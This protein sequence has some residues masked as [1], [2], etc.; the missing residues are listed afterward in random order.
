MKIKFSHFQASMNAMFLRHST[1]EETETIFYSLR[2]QSL[3]TFR[4]Q[5][6]ATT[7]QQGDASN[8][9]ALSCS[10]ACPQRKWGK[11]LDS[12]STRFSPAAGN[13]REYMNS[14]KLS[15]TSKFFQKKQK[16]M[17]LTF[18]EWGISHKLYFLLKE[19]S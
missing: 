16:S 2:M 19:S 4:I 15:S 3:M 8:P 1:N 10:P 5:R 11:Y 6:A 12:P 14:T 7:F 9:S 18:A 17:G 13:Y